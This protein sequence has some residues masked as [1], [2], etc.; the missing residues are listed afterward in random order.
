MP[1]PVTSARPCSIGDGE[2]MR[3]SRFGAIGHW[4]N[5]DSQLRS[6][7]SIS[8]ECC[9]F[10]VPLL[11]KRAQGKPGADCARSPVCKKCAMKAHGLTTGTAETS[12][13]SP[14]NGF[15]AYTRSPRG[16]GLSCPRCQWEDSRQ[17]SARVAAPGPHD[18]AVRRGVFVR[19]TCVALTP[20]RPSQPAPT[21]R[22]NRDA[23]LR[24]HGMGDDILPIYV[25]VKRHFGNSLSRCRNS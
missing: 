4:V 15:T 10:V 12:R 20:Q 6:R 11:E 14:R 7:G 17:R 23:P 5:R 21:C 18:F 8:P 22:D 1:H 13:L 25:I 9:Q 16:S 19:A 3:P 2:R 24:R